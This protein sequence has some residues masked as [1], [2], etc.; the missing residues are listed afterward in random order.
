MFISSLSNQHIKDIIRLQTKSSAR[1]KEKLF[2]AEG[3]KMYEEAPREDIVNTY[4]SES[5]LKE[6]KDRIKGSYIIVKDNIF[7]DISDT[8]TPQGIICILRQ[9][10]YRLNEILEKEKKQIFILLESLQDPGNLG[11]IMR[12]AEGAGA[13]VIMNKSTVDLFNPKVVRSTMGSVFRVPFLV[14]EDLAA[15][16]EVL[17]ENRVTIYAAH[18]DGGIY[19]NEES[20]QTSSGFIIG[21][22]A[23]G[24]TEEIRRQADQLVSIPMEGKLESLNAAVTAAILMYKARSD[25]DIRESRDCKRRL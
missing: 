2:V 13:A 4:V 21:N 25:F 5:F 24:L 12:T 17:K 9:K 8:V 18:L 22:E 19:Y 7:K 1:K 15:A 3:I 20:Y 11:T 10:E 23:R 14:F 16:V 6:N